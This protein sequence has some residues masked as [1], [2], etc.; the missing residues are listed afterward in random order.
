MDLGQ[1]SET[2]RDEVVRWRR[3]LHRHAEVGWTEFRTTS[4]LVDTL[5]ELGY[6]VAYGPDIHSREHRLGVPSDDVLTAARD[7]AVRQG[8]S[9]AHV[10]HMGEG[11]TGVVATLD[12]GREGP[13]LGLRFD[14]DANDVI[15]TDV[16]EHPPVREGFASVNHGAMHACGHDAHTAI[17]VGVAILL[18][19]HV[20]LF[21]GT[22]TLVFQPAEEGVRGAE[23]L[24]AA[25]VL[26]DVDLFVAVHMEAG[27]PLGTVDCGTRGFLATTKF[28]VTF[29]GEGAHAGNTPEQGGNALLAA[30]NAALNLHAIPRHSGGITRVNVGTLRAGTGRNVIPPR[31]VMEVETRGETTEVSE[32]VFVRA[33]AVVAGCAGAYG[34]GHDVTVTG[35]A[36]VCEPSEELVRRAETAFGAVPSVRECVSRARG[37]T[38]SEDATTMMRRVQDNGG[39]ATYI[40]LGS[41]ISYGHHTDRFDIDEDVLPLGV[42]GVFNLA[43]ATNGTPRGNDVV[44]TIGVA[45]E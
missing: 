42:Q 44:T 10:E 9:P 28:D 34:V 15:E 4:L 33:Q 31:A 30:A 32:D 18:A 22:F 16:E 3:D 14:I 37:A 45:D 2:V 13:T 29:H 21:T 11:F 25:G 26:D 7:R 12:T 38:G 43:R 8:A 24:V 40:M 27:A 20:E 36:D 6:Q 41:A 5:G 17:G 39:L 35:R 19:R 23:S 1:A